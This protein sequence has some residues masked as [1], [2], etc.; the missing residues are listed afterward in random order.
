M[1]RAKVSRAIEG[2]QAGVRGWQAIRVAALGV[3]DGGSLTA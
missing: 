2:H 1:G 3:L